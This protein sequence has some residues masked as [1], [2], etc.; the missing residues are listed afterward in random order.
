M[1][2]SFLAAPKTACES[3]Y[4]ISTQLISHNYNESANKDGEKNLDGGR[5]KKTNKEVNKTKK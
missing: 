4:T 2:K 1:K 5:S 3:F